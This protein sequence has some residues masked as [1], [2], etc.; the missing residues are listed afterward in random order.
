MLPPAGE[1]AAAACPDGSV[2]F[3]VEKRL[4]DFINR[5]QTLRADCTARM[6]FTAKKAKK[7]IYQVEARFPGNTVLKPASKSRRF[8]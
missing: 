4:R 2:T 7:R 6:R 8:S 1:T 5:Q 3:V